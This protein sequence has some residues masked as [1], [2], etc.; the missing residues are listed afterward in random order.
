MKFLWVLVKEE[1]WVICEIVVAFL[2]Y[3]LRIAEDVARSDQGT[4]RRTVGFT[5]IYNVS[6]FLKLLT[7]WVVRLGPGQLPPIEAHLLTSECC[8][9][10]VGFSTTCLDSTQIHSPIPEATEIQWT[11]RMSFK[12]KTRLLPKRVSS[13]LP[14]TSAK[15]LES[16]FDSWL[17]EFN[18]SNLSPGLQFTFTRLKSESESESVQDSDI[19]LIYLNYILNAKLWDFW[20]V[21]NSEAEWLTDTQTRQAKCSRLD[22]L[23]VS[24]S[25]WRLIVANNSIYPSVGHNLTPREYSNEPRD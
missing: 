6:I 23:L 21:H 5:M 19:N 4:K 15:S 25:L 13:N 9:R 14:Q 1:I 16:L 8:H 20:G 2:V 24:R 3:W 12:L 18:P 11:N 22:S 17:A 10:S 7:L